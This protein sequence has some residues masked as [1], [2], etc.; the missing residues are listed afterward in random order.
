MLKSIPISIALEALPLSDVLVSGQVFLG[1]VSLRRMIVLLFAVRISDACQ[2]VRSASCKVQNHLSS[3]TTRT[4]N[5]PDSAR[6]A[7]DAL[8][9]GGRE[10]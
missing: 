6:A 7:G 9:A 5:S 3:S 1:F 8:G 2:Q 4:W 10:F